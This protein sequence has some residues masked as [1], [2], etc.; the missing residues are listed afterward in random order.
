MKKLKLNIIALISIFTLF[1][2]LFTSCPPN[3]ESKKDYKTLTLD[4]KTSYYF[5]EGKWYDNKACETPLE[6]LTIAQPANK[7]VIITLDFG[8]DTATSPIEAIYLQKGENTF[9]FVFDK[10]TQEGLDVDFFESGLSLPAD[11]IKNNVKLVSKYDETKEE[12]LKLPPLTDGDGAFL[13]YKLNGNG[14]VINSETEIT[15]KFDTPNSKYIAGWNFALKLDNT[16]RGYFNG[17]GW[18]MDQQ[19]KYPLQNNKVIIPNEI[20][21]KAT[22]DLADPSAT[23]E[24]AT[25]LTTT[26]KFLGYF[27]KDEFGVFVGNAKIGSNGSV[28]KYSITKN[29]ELFGRNEGHFTK[30]QDPIRDEYRFDGWI[31]EGESNMYDFENTVA[32]DGIKLIAQWTFLGVETEEID[33]W[34]TGLK[35]IVGNETYYTI[36]GIN[37][38]Q[39]LSSETAKEL[40]LDGENINVVYNSGTYGHMTTALYRYGESEQAENTI[41]GKIS[42]RYAQNSTT[43]SL[44]LDGKG[45]RDDISGSVIFVDGNKTTK[46]DLSKFIQYGGQSEGEIEAD[47]KK[48]VALMMGLSFDKSEE[49]R[50]YIYERIAY[51]NITNINGEQDIYTNGTLISEGNFSHINQ[52]KSNGDITL[53][54]GADS[55]TIN[56]DITVLPRSG[57]ETEDIKVTA[58]SYMNIKKVGD[59]FF[60]KFPLTALG[61]V[62]EE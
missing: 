57:T 53:I 34:K 56:F 3:P 39:I 17:N 46:L 28:D 29:T 50:K 13:G 48:P 25:E 27:E 60:R 49:V 19:C 40:S 32:E 18:Y 51:E 23:I 47:Y 33:A 2:V 12:K 10:Y 21:Y 54:I 30:P 4:G 11:G 24:G 6:D 45:T 55:L 41:K 42:G 16:V 38:K 20:S 58:G 35:S 31:K 36:T 5:F 61:Y 15:V 1:M 26:S 44:E 43:F 14:E 9:S 7:D 22:L 37:T 52:Y 62:V 8:S 59:D